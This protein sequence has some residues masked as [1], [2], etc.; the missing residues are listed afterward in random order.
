MTVYHGSRAYGGMYGAFPIPAK[1]SDPRIL[2]PMWYFNH[3]DYLR[4]RS[5]SAG[6]DYTIFRPD[7]IGGV[8]VG[9]PTNIVVA[10]AVYAAICKELGQPLRFPGQAHAMDTLLQFTDARLIGRATEWAMG[11]SRAAN[12]IFNIANGDQVRWQRL[13]PRIAKYFDMPVEEPIDYPLATLIPRICS[14]SSSTKCAPSACCLLSDTP[15]S[16]SSVGGPAA[17]G[18]GDLNHFDVSRR[19]EGV[20]PGF[21]LPVR[22]LA[23]QNE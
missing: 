16:R 20:R 2:P 10:V 12:E 1:E 18:Y 4:E 14:S 13:W 11:S 6:F 3:E 23:T 8:A 7:I 9:N 15:G 5:A 21:E 17:P 22:R 19:L